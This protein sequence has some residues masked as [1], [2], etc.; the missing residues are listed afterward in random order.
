MFLALQTSAA[1]GLHDECY[2]QMIYGQFMQ[3]FKM[4]SSLFKAAGSFW[5]LV[6]LDCTGFGVMA[7]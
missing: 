3:Y 6:L 2:M 7:P 4:A 5:P 1:V